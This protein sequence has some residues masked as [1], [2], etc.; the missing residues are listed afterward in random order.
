MIGETGVCG[1]GLQPAL[2]GAGP[3][4][5]CVQGFL[6]LVQMPAGIFQ[7]IRK[8]AEFGFHL[9]QQTPDLGGALL[10]G[11]GAETQLQRAEHGGFRCQRRDV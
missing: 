6:G 2:D 9:A 4:S 10:D 8:A 11:H 7:M 3:G 1:N 5:G